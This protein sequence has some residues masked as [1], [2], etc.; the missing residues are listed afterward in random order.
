MPKTLNKKNGVH[1]RT[2]RKKPLLSKR[3]PIAAR[4][5]FAEVHLG[6][7]QRYWQILWTNETTVVVWKE[8]ITLC[9]GGKTAQHT[10]IKTSSQL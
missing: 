1:G 8:H 9:R 4:L 5:K 3:N 2:P 6:F 7:P 10:N